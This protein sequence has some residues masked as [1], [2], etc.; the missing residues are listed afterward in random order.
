MFK[1]FSA[2]V[3]NN[4]ENA[5]VVAWSFALFKLII[6]CQWLSVINTNPFLFNQINQI[7]I[8]RAQNFSPRNRF[9]A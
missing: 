5:S 2:Y 1:T 3:L 6:I 9:S 8:G 7:T 4:N